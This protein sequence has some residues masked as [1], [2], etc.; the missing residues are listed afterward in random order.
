MTHEPPDQLHGVARYAVPSLAIVIVLLAFVAS[1]VVCAGCRTVEVQRTP[2]EVVKPYIHV[3]PPIVEVPPITPGSPSAW[4]IVW[5]IVAAGAVLMLL[6]LIVF[7]IA[8][9]LATRDKAGAKEAKP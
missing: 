5:S 1:C 8:A 9:S 3:E 4:G 2:P 6:N 7:G